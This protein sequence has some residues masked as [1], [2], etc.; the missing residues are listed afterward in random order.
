MLP[1]R[2]F[3]ACHNKEK[4]YY[5]T[6]KKSWKLNWSHEGHSHT[7]NNI[8]MRDNCTVKRLSESEV[9]ECLGLKLFFFFFLQNGETYCVTILTFILQHNSQ[10][11]EMKGWQTS[12]ANQSGWNGALWEQN[13]NF[14]QQQNLSFGKFSAINVTNANTGFTI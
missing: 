11:G 2:Y 9:I 7:M 13:I 4:R 5:N 8:K 6:K 12:Q 14:F 3:L 10:K 1:R